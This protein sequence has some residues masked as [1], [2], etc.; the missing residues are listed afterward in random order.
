[1]LLEG[2]PQAASVL[3]G[4]RIA[5]MGDSITS[6]RRSYYNVIYTALKDAGVS[7]YDDSV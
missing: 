7:F 5:F 3:R 4:K 6:D 2:H 1:M